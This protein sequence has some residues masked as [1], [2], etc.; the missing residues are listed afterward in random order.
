MAAKLP[1]FAGYSQQDAQE[2]LRF[3]L[4][5]LHEVL[6]GWVLIRRSH[7]SRGRLARISVIWPEGRFAMNSA[8]DGGRG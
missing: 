1:N 3:M 5:S 8:Q 6:D 2:F 7:Y 4:D